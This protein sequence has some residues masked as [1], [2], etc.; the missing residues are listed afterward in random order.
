MT[1][2]YSWTIEG[3]NPDL[4]GDGVVDGTDLSL[5]LGFWGT[6]S[7]VADINLDGLVNGIDLSIVLG[8]W[9]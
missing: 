6:D 2:S 4:N 1:D 9:G 5:V 7:A 8:F 3:Q